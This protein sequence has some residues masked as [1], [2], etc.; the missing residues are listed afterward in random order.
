MTKRFVTSDT[1]FNHDKIIKFERPDFMG[2]DTTDSEDLDNMEDFIIERWNKVVK[3]EDTV[4]HL[5]DFALGNRKDIPR[6]TARLNGNIVLIL[7]NHDRSEMLKNPAKWGFAE[8]HAFGL[9]LKD[10]SLCHYR[11]RHHRR[12]IGFHGHEHRT[13][14]RLRIDPRD[15]A[16]RPYAHVNVCV[17][18]W[19]YT[20]QNV[21]HLLEEVDSILSKSNFLSVAGGEDSSEIKVSAFSNLNPPKK[22]CMFELG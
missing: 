8:V 1:H 10:V 20:P 16:K 4:Y 7:G 13:D 19:D 11:M 5:G 12:R 18:N 3:P 21:D 15:H 9:D 17:E 22:G 6:I 2:I 14:A